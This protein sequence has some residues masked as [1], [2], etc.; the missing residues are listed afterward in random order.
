MK[1][2]LA[3]GSKSRL[4]LLDTI[5]ITPDLIEA[6]D[7]EEIR[8]K[9]EKPQEMCARLAKEKGEKIAAKYPNDFILSADTVSCVGTRILDK[10]YDPEIEKKYLE[11]ISGKRHRLYS[12]VCGFVKSKDFFVQKTSMSILKFK[13]FSKEEIEKIIECEEWKGCSGGYAIEGFMGQYLTWVSGSV[14]NIMGLP[15]HE[16]NNILSSSNFNFATN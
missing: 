13:R 3:S 14:S 9:K 8:Q 15:L 5:K 16:V 2:I 4:R 12:S 1:F 6:A 11:L 10:T 7:I